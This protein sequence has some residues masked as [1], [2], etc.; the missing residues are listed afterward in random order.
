MNR[1]SRPW[2]FAPVAVAVLLAGAAGSEDT[3]RS[4]IAHERAEIEARHAARE[5]ACRERVVVRSCGEDAKRE[6]RQSR[7]DL[8]AR[9]H[10]LDE[11]TRRER[12]E[13]RR[14]ELA[15]KA[16]EDARR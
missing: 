9:Q 10:K 8:R 13:A 15:A 5:R 12:T 6:R 11:E 2:L 3:E 14:A 7:D 16:A 1:R 4:Q